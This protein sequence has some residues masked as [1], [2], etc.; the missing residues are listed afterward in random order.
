MGILVWQ[1]IPSRAKQASWNPLAGHNGEEIK[2]SKESADNYRTEWKAIIDSLRNFPSIVVWV[3]FNEAW[4]QFDTV[5]IANWTMQHDP[6]RLVNAASGG[7]DF[8]AGHISDPHG[9]PCPI[10]PAL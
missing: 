1:Y 3:P 9:Y 6:S 2:R 5:N 4:G 7:N 8:P 10:M